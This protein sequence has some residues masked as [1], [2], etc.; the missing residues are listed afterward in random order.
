MRP[1]AMVSHPVVQPGYGVL[2]IQ[3]DIGEAAC[4]GKSPC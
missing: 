4:V 3:D 2:S 1:F